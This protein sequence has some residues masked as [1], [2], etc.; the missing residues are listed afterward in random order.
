MQNTK[1]E[2]RKLHVQSFF[3][4]HAG[5]F[6][7]YLLLIG[8]AYIFIYP[9]MIMFAQSIQNVFDQINPMVN[10]FP[11]EVYWENYRR[12]LSAMGGQSTY[13]SSLINIG[14]IA[15]VQ[16]VTSAL[17]GYSLGKFE[18]W[19][20][21]LALGIIVVMFIIPREIFLLP[22][23][24]TMSRVGLLGSLNPVLILS[25]TGQG[26]SNAIYIL[27]FYSFFRLQP[28]SLDEAAYV[29][30]AGHLRTFWQIN[31][32]MAKGAFIVNVILS[33]VWNW[34]DTEINNTFFQGKV[35][36]VQL[37]LQN[38][39]AL[40]ERMFPYDMMQSTTLD[41]FSYGV[42]MAGAILAIIP[43]IVFYFIIQRYIVQGIEQTGITG[44]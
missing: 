35:T 30:G 14:I 7:I 6:M 1:L 25:A 24:L 32:P 8:I 29:D 13:I 2:N 16:T 19:W 12:A 21:K 10:W 17:I 31:V 28:K 26:I 34:N 4:K 5:H 40:Y 38:F 18:Y 15:I 37:R 43:L 9:L 3:H 41:R 44:E 11:E 20:T 22:Q 23:Y 27:I 39:A 36:T 33:F 42:E